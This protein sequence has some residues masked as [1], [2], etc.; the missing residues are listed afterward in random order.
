MSTNDYK[1]SPVT[2]N[3]SV[4]FLDGLYLDFDSG[5]HRYDD[6]DVNLFIEKSPDE[7]TESQITDSDGNVWFKISMFTKT[8]GLLPQGS[9]WVVVKWKSDGQYNFLSDDEV[10]TSFEDAYNKFQQLKNAE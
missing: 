7:V 9:T 10:F 5:Y 4:L 8:L 2:G 1:I 3:K 6:W